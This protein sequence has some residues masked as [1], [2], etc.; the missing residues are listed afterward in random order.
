MLLQIQ[1]PTV[2]NRDCS[3]CQI[4]HYNE[5][6]G[7]PYEGRDGQPAKRH[8]G[9]PPTCRTDQGCPKGTPEESKGLSRR[10]QRTLAFIRECQAV[11]HFPDDPIVRQMAT[12]VSH[13]DRAETVKHRAEISAIVKGLGGGRNHP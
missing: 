13:V 8:K 11:E 12:I 10:N 7:Q 4:Y 6:T 1:H 9:C 2:A 5:E 3:H